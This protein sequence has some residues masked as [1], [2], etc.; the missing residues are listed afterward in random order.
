[1]RLLITKIEDDESE[2]DEKY[3]GGF[4]VFGKKMVV[5]GSK[6]LYVAD[7]E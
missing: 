6:G 5:Y 2:E 3:L 1:M 7:L 4:A